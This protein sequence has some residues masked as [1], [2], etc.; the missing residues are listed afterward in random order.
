MINKEVEHNILQAVIEIEKL[1]PTVHAHEISHRLSLDLDEVCAY[2]EH[3]QL[4]GCVKL[5]KQNFIGEGECVFVEMTSI[6][7]MALQGRNEFLYKS[8]EPS[9]TIGNIE[10]I[11]SSI[12]ANNIHS[13]QFQLGSYN[14]TQSL[15]T[16]SLNKDEIREILKEAK[17][18]IA[19]CDQPIGDDL[20]SD[21]QTIEAQL[22]K[23]EPKKNILATSLESV[24]EGISSIIK[25]SAEK[26][27]SDVVIYQAHSMLQ[28]IHDV[29]HNLSA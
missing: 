22:S 5:N 4:L 21:I 20:Q 11:G 17:Q 9:I 24:K 1:Y 15:S 2:L 12:R 14:S 16:N 10:N 8:S 18:L 19:Y 7:R 25:K 23:S 29:L 27:I 6:G 13:S 26:M 3:L 28:K